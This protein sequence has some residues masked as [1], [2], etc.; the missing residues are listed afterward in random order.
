MKKSPYFRLNIEGQN[1]P[2]AEAR[3][4]LQAPAQNGERRGGLGSTANDDEG[5]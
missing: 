4:H 3:V 5:D 1:Q 2:K